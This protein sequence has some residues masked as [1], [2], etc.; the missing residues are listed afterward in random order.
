M[1]KLERLCSQKQDKPLRA[2]RFLERI[3]T[4]SGDDRTRKLLKRLVARDGIEPPT[5][6][7]QGSALTY[8]LVDSVWLTHHSVGLTPYYWN[9]FGTCL[10]GQMP[11][12]SATSVSLLLAAVT[13][14]QT[15]G[16]CPT[17]CLL[18]SV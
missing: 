4:Y 7:F 6:A 8:Y 14:E 1:M 2:V 15:A 5:P 3:G 17:L 11:R 10:S 9:V 13:R 12:Q 16:K 18:V